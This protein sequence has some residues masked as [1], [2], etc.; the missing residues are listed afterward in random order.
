MSP[1]AAAL[2]AVA[3]SFPKP[4][5]SAEPDDAY[6]ARLETISEA[7]A[8]ETE[9]VKNGRYAVAAAVL[10]TFRFESGF[11]FEV[12]SGALKGDR[13]RASCL[14]QQWQNGRTREEWEALAGTSLE[15]TR[16]CARATV[17]GL[18]RAHRHCA[19]NVR[20][21]LDRAAVARAF[22][23]YG[24]GRDC[25]PT[26]SSERRAAEWSRVLAD[27]RSQSRTPELVATRQ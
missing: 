12:H 19:R 6:R 14:S 17:E 21:V 27:M 4:W 5:G 22:R 1:L 10:V 26:A 8:A 15:A 13:G 2:L 25:R 11:R 16:R 9:P 24:S 20:S 23:L 7:I 3:L 18:L